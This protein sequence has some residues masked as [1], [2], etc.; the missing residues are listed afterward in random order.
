MFILVSSTSKNKTI[1]RLIDIPFIGPLLVMF[2]AFLPLVLAGAWGDLTN[3][4][5]SQIVLIVGS[6]L[7]IAWNYYLLTRE[8]VIKIVGISAWVWSI[9]FSIMILFSVIN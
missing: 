9:I 1:N 7:S 5:A 8:T 4:P 3:S 2:Y 6:F